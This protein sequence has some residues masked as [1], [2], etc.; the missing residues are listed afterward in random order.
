MFY[1]A[2]GEII[3]SDI[4]NNLEYKLLN[5]NTDY[6]SYI[7]KNIPLRVFQVYHTKSKIPDYVYTNIKKYAP[8][9]EYYVLDDNDCIIFLKTYFK[10]IVSDTFNEL[11]IGPHK[12]DLVRYCLLY[13]YG[14]VYLDIKIELMK[15]LSEIFTDNQYIY[16]VLSSAKDHIFQAIIASRPTNPFFLKLINHIV[17]TKNP[18][19]YLNYCKDFYNNIII[20]T[21]KPINLEINIGK[22]QNFFIFDDRCSRDASSCYDGLD[23]YGLCCFV[24]HKEEKIMKARY[25]SY[26]W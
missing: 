23:K 9:Y 8:E 18:D 20:E 7:S 22:T 14:G 3:N 15:P 10:P 5:T 12:A 1:S 11:K 6:K 4:N 17:N 26:P 2:N 21:G 24:Y 16:S 19:D 25:A 13:I